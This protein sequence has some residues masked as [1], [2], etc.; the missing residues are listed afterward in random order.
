MLDKTLIIDGQ[1]SV[2]M[3]K[4]QPSKY[5]KFCCLLE[6]H[7]QFQ[8]TDVKSVS[9]TT[10]KSSQTNNDSRGY[11]TTQTIITYRVRFD[12]VNGQHFQ[13]EIVM[14]PEEVQQIVQFFRSF[15]QGRQNVTPQSIPISYPQYYPVGTSET[16]YSLD[17]PYS[18]P[19]YP[20]YDP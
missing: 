10:V 12:F 2:G 17:A 18:Y 16:V 8:L 19:A 14:K 9:Q 5:A 4:S 1:E 20:P 13:P 3:F 15:N 6:T 7:R 11:R